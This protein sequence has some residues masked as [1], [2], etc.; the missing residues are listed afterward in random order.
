M[1]SLVRVAAVLATGCSYPRLSADC[2]DPLACPAGSRPGSSDASCAALHLTPTKVVPS[3]ELLIDRSGSMAN[4]FSDMPPTGG[5]PVKY[6]AMRDALVGM[7]GVVTTLA[8]QVYFGASLYADDG[9]T[10]PGL[11]TVARALNNAMS[12]GTLVDVNPPAG[13]TPTPP[14]IDA[15][16]AD[17][18]FNS[19]P[20]DS[21][22]IIV[23]ATDG[24]PNA[25]GNST[26]PTQ[27][28]AIAAAANA[29]AHGIPLYVL[30]VGN[31]TAATSMHFQ[32]LANA[33]AGVQPG[34]PNAVYYPATS[35]DQ[36]TSA[37]GTIVGGTIKSSCD[38]RLTT[39][40]DPVLAPRSTATLDGMALAYNVDW[41][42]DSNGFGFHLVGAACTAIQASKDPQLDVAFPCSGG[43]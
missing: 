9:K 29:F 1:K 20:S 36:L 4:D 14:A 12:I 34:Q 5:S 30:S 23:L 32:A 28:Q 41:T 7:Q 40:I 27:P 26:T 10:C 25:C 22:P 11:Q 39:P 21:P 42:L 33:G 24:L 2:A 43:G 16:V 13:N 37:L 6:T 38:L 19:P 3:V 17:F 31:I 15:V 8:S 18:G 35:P